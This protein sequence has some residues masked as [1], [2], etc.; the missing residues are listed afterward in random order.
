MSDSDSSKLISATSSQVSASS[1]AFRARVIARRGGGPPGRSHRLLGVH[2]SQR[3]SSLHLDEDALAGALLGRL[4]N[5]VLEPFGDDRDA[6]R[7]A[8]FAL[9]VVALFHV[10]ETVVEQPK[11]CWCDLLTEPVTGAQVLIDPD[12]HDA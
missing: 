11:D 7:S 9:H 1:E 12:L 2:I 5:G 3:H 10:G 4:A 8:G 6:A